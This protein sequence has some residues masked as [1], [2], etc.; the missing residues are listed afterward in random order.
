[1][2]DLPDIPTTASALPRNILKRNSRV[3][4]KSRYTPSWE[5][6]KRDNQILATLKVKPE[7]TLAEREA[8]FLRYRK[9]LSTRKDKDV[10]YR[11]QFPTAKL[12]VVS[13][14]L[15]KMQFHIKLVHYAQ[16][17]TLSDLTLLG[18]GDTNLPTEIGVSEHDDLHT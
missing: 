10:K 14:N 13:K 5:A 16:E 18:L 8:I 1:M 12:Q 9:A 4:E 6:L 2:T 11:E 15:D 3:G 7:A 17:I